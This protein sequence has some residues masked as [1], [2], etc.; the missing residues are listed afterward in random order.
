M[1]KDQRTNIERKLRENEIDVVVTTT[2]LEVGI[3]IGGITT[4]ITPIVPV[5]RLLQRIGRAGRGNQPAKISLELEHDPI[6]FYY[7]THAN[8]YLK[9]VSAVNITTVLPIANRDSVDHQ[10]P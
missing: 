8:S 5:N 4:I 7:S 2:T 6:S 9:D 10:S 3:D 1:G